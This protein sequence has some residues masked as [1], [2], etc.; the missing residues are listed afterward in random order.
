MARIIFFRVPENFKPPTAPSYKQK[1]GKLLVFGKRE[2][3]LE[4]AAKVSACAESV[5]SS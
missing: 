3:R 2:T 4:W 1:S 5:Q